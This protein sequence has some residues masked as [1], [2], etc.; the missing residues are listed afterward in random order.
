MEGVSCKDRRGWGEGCSDGEPQV[1]RWE[2]AAELRDPLGL[3]GRR[4]S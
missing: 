1:G 4:E 2:G 3:R